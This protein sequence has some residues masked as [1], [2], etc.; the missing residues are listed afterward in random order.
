MGG[1]RTR[2]GP[3]H[4]PRP[5]TVRTAVGAFAVAGLAAVLV[6]SL[7]VVWAV[8]RGATASSVRDARDLTVTAGRSAVSPVLSDGIFTSDPAA[9][10]ALDRAVRAQVLSDRVVRVKVWT[11]DGRILYSDEPALIGRVFPLSAEEQRVLRDGHPAANVTDLGEPENTFER[12]YKKLLQVYDELA[13]PSGKPVL[14]EAYLRFSTVSSDTDRTLRSVAPAVLAGLALLFLT[15]L[16]LAWTMA[17]RL[18][19]GRA[20][21]ERLLRKALA[22]G[23][24][25]R[26]HIA[27]D[28]H[29]G[30]VQ[31][32]AGTALSLTAS[33]ERAAKAGLT[34]VAADVEEA[35]RELRQGIRD[36]RTL[37]VAI[38]PPRLH[39]EGLEPALAD[40]V[41]PLRA[42]G[43]NT[44]LTVADSLSVERPVEALVYRAAQEAVRN[45]ARHADARRVD[46]RLAGHDAMIRLEVVDDGVGFTEDA[47]ATRRAAGHVGLQ[48]VSELADE[49]GGR[50]DVIS[51]AGEGTRVVL[52]VPAR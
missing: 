34:E 22:A 33:A 16:P 15:Q 17:R 40:L 3:L 50:L 20:E 51:A 1:L 36:L 23:E 39:D 37:I 4:H 13:T 45:I 49:A 8:R 25:E 24:L 35:A 19:R 42:R 52:E 31:A 9:L 48:L 21:E 28:L 11:P 47:L 43:I 18:Q 7:A 12:P 46:V 2:R 41:S 5:I 44:T 29:D 10:S 27:A 32:L 14:F 26:R 38:A 30:S 6:I